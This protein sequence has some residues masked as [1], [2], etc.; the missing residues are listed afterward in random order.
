MFYLMQL[1]VSLA[2][3]RAAQSRQHAKSRKSV[4]LDDEW[5]NPWTRQQHRLKEALARAKAENWAERRKQVNSTSTPADLDDE[6]VNPWSRRQRWLKEAE[7]LAR[8]KP[9]IR[10]PENPGRKARTQRSHDT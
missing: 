6:W 8:A 10:R 1:L 3:D 2:F 5:V 4:D 9:K 7:A